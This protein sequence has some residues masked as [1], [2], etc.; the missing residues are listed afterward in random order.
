MGWI[1][2]YHDEFDG[3]L[4]EQEEG[5][6]DALLF[7]IE[8]LQAEGPMLGRP[9]VDTVKGSKYPNMKELRVQYKGEPW[10]VLFAFDPKRRA[11]ILVGG[12]K[13]GRSSNW[14]KENIRIAEKRFEQHLNT[15]NEEEK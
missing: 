11:I 7:S 1:V 15:M 4:N 3:W 6:Q 2:L 13:T 14:Y 8:L 12:N 5:L 9:Y 10:R